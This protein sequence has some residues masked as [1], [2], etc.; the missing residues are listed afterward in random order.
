MIL[1]PDRLYKLLP[2]VY[3]QRD[4]EAGGPLKALLGVISEQVNVV[5]RDIGQTYQNWFIETCEEWAVPYIGA[6]IGYQ[7]ATPASLPDSV[8]TA[9]DRALES[10]LVPRRDV[11]A[12]VA[13]RLR[14][15][16]LAILEQLATDLTGWSARVT[17]LDQQCAITQSLKSSRPR[18]GRVMDLRS[19]RVLERLG[20]A[21][22]QAGRTVRLADDDLPHAGDADVLN[23]VRL[24]LW[25]L[26][27]FALDRVPAHC[28]VANGDRC[29]T[30]SALGDDLPLYARPG[31]ALAGTA[32]AGAAVRDERAVLPGPITRL[33]LA[34]EKPRGHRGRLRTSP[35]YYGAGRSLA[36]WA[37]QWAGLDAGQPV[38]ADRVI[39]ADLSAWRYEPPPDHIAVDPQLGRI[40][41]PPGQLP[42]GGVWVTYCYASPAALGAGPYPR[43]LAYPTGTPVFFV[44]GGAQYESIGQALGAWRDQAPA[45]AIIEV[46]DSAIYVETLRVELAAG[47]RLELRAISGARP[48]IKLFDRRGNRPIAFAVAGETGSAFGID[49]LVLEGRS[50]EIEG[51]LRSFT[52]RDC[53]L[54][55]GWGRDDSRAAR[56]PEPS[57]MFV[58]TAVAIRIERSVIGAIRVIRT[59][60]D[61]APSPC[62]I[63][64]SVVDA[65]AEAALAIGGENGRN[66]GVALTLRRSTILGQ[67]RVHAIVLAENA[68]FAGQLHV[69]RRQQGCV[70]CCYVPPDSRTP[71]RFQCQP[72]LAERALNEALE[73]EPL[74]AA[75]RSGL[76]SAERHRVRP[77]F[78]STQRGTPGYVQLAGRC[79]REISRGAEDASE[80]GVYHDLFVPQRQDMLLERI[81][82]SVPLGV[83]AG[84]T[85]VD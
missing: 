30:F 58:D 57:L 31:A 74:S 42:V 23:K 44:G 34:E 9:D 75:E 62:L 27:V 81:E 61:L 28:L 53:T 16:T 76:V 64:T 59:R 1:D 71:P 68:I 26:K 51:S 38:P 32:P 5:D 48:V 82:G 29:F 67:V 24:Y 37:P 69:A 41:F 66:A 3:R 17:E 78:T 65:Q 39:P 60:P 18:R 77:V 8:A 33:E 85:F 19:R 56:G 40:A 14:K 2:A 46:I 47:Q 12:T 7:V 25:R 49:G 73:R 52:V 83:A 20:G 21:F 80:M 4:F 13:F 63:D 50:F 36:V 54:I 70:R 11:A 22:D 10:V 55:A 15:G 35:V 72:E 43:R 84:I 6:L 45:H 79:P